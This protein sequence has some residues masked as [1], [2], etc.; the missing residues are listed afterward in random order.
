MPSSTPACSTTIAGGRW[1]VGAVGCDAAC[2]WSFQ[3]GV[4]TVCRCCRPCHCLQV[5]LGP[6]SGADSIGWHSDSEPLYGREPTIATVSL[7]EPRE[8]LL[9]RNADHQERYRFRL[10]GGALLVMSGPVQEQ[11]GAARA[12]HC[13]LGGGCCRRGA[14][15]GGGCCGRWVQGLVD[16]CSCCDGDGRAPVSHQHRSA[17]AW[18]RSGCTAFP[19][20]LARLG[21]ASRSRSASSRGQSADAAAAA[22]ASRQL[23]WHVMC[24]HTGTA[25]QDAA[26]KRWRGL[27][28][29]G[30]RM[31]G[32]RR[33]QR[34]PPCRR[35][36]SPLLPATRSHSPVVL[37]ISP[38]LPSCPAAQGRHHRAAARAAD[39][40]RQVGSPGRLDL[41]AWH[42]LNTLNGRWVRGPPS[43]A[44]KQRGAPKPA[45]AARFT[46]PGGLRR[47]RT[48]IKPPPTRPPPCRS[49]SAAAASRRLA[50]AAAHRPRMRGTFL[51]LAVLLSAGSTA[52]AANYGAGLSAAILLALQARCRSARC[53]QLSPSASLGPCPA[54]AEPTRLLPPAPPPCRHAVHYV[55]GA[56]RRLSV[57][58]LQQVWRPA[59]R[60]G[61]R[62]G[63]LPARLGLVHHAAG[64]P[65]NLPARLRPRL[66]LRDRLWW[67]PAQGVW[68]GWEEGALCALRCTALHCVAC[69]SSSA[70]L[71]PCSPAL[72]RRSAPRSR[73]PAGDVATC[74]A[75]QVQQGDTLTLIASVFG[76]YSGVRGDGMGGGAACVS[77][78]AHQYSSGPQDWFARSA[79]A[80]P[81]DTVLPT[82]HPCIAHPFPM[83][84]TWCP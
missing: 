76:I 17:A 31:A 56:E 15:L 24:N 9:R 58:H 39:K 5:A 50:A 65:K 37:R 12:A 23:S 1:V 40:P 72:L 60:P 70:G 30:C 10:G 67:V 13:L 27:Q 41:A 44:A 68:A 18:C 26:V 28:D 77:V 20:G 38:G 29:G 83:F 11:V 54:P 19:S 22:R 7:G 74:K 84:R 16:G 2:G 81:P 3:R 59:G 73:A 82:N 43:R 33:A 69:L 21:S 49:S 35:P 78:I 25:P 34:A 55:C 66:R 52:W 51:L 62:P 4:P 46:R 71:H 57:V 8:F 14:L 75:Y 42:H 45:L 53:T 32:A 63:V 80:L 48:S 6:R 64:R 36:S 61:R 47:P 79:A